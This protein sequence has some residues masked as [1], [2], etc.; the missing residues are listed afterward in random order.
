MS[1][2]GRPWP[3]QRS[4][5]WVWDIGTLTWVVMTQPGGG[6]G[7][8]VNITQVGGV[9]VTLGQAAMAASFPVVI[10]SDQ[11]PVIVIAV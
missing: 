9:S 11:S 10:A 2:H 7:G 6:G 5:N 3:T 4:L 1:A 8:D